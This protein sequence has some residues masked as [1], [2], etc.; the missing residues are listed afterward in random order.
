MARIPI[1]H[2]SW[3][4]DENA[5]SYTS[6]QKQRTFRKKRQVCVLNVE[7]LQNVAWLSQPSEGGAE[8]VAGAQTLDPDGTGSS[9]GS[10]TRGCGKELNLPA[11]PWARLENGAGS[12]YEDYLR[13]YLQRAHTNTWHMVTHHPR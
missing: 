8:R 5:S 12:R 9:P 6:R 11:G 10:A 1:F 2:L 3:N 4:G 13:S 7:Q